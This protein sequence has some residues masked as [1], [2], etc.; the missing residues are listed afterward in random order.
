M[1]TKFIF[2]L[3]QLYCLLFFS[4]SFINGHLSYKYRNRNRSKGSLHNTH[5]AQALVL[6]ESTSSSS[7]LSSSSSNLNNHQSQIECDFLNHKETGCEDEIGSRCDPNT[8]K[9]VCKESHPVRLLDF[10]LKL[11]RLNGPCYTSGQCSS[12]IA[13]ASC[14]I[15]GKEYDLDSHNLGRLVTKWP[16]GV[17]KC[18]LGFAYNITTNSCEKRV[19]GSWCSMDKHCWT[20]RSLN[21]ISSFCDKKRG[22]CE[23]AWGTRYESKLDT[24]VPD[25]TP[26]NS[27]RNNGI[28]YPNRQVYYMSKCEQDTDCSLTSTSSSIQTT[29]SSSSGN[30]LSSTNSPSIHSTVPSTNSPSSPKPTSVSS[31]TSSPAVNLIHQPNVQIESNNLLLEQADQENQFNQIRYLHAHRRFKDNLKRLTNYHLRELKCIRG[32]CI[33]PALHNWDGNL[34]CREYY[35]VQSNSSHR[36]NRKNH[37]TFTDLDDEL[38]DEFDEDSSVNWQTICLLILGSSLLAGFIFR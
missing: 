29:S 35:D 38:N 23:C 24:C 8:S 15:F 20:I 37:N 34:H 5:T 13:N 17:C 18:R 10:C 30:S 36:H 28:N 6:A 25:T 9:C 14:Y 12:V 7:S 32:R 33:C 31:S 19:I 26:V 11:S 27:L 22:E 1:Q 3:L 4:F 16:L 21:S 2:I